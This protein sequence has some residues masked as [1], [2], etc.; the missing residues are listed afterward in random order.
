MMFKVN[1]IGILRVLKDE[2]IEIIEII[3]GYRG[4]DIGVFGD[5][6]IVLLGN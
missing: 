6:E 4:V 5:G 2:E 3:C 1:F